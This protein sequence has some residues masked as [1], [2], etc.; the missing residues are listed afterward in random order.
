MR[1]GTTRGPNLTGATSFAHELTLLG[2]QTRRLVM[3][4]DP[5][6][7]CPPA[8]PNIPNAPPERSSTPNLAQS[9]QSLSSFITDPWARTRSRAE[10]YL[11]DPKSDDGE[12]EVDCDRVVME[13]PKLPGRRDSLLCLPQAKKDIGLQR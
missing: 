11:R 9:V 5:G 6:V 7:I 1:Q 2:G 8:R 13:P 3:K 12:D 10:T 4:E